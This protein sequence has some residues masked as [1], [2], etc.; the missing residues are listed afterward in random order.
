MRGPSRHS[1]SLV[2]VLGLALGGLFFLGT[3]AC[4]SILGNDG[5]SLAPGDAGLEV[6]DEVTNLDAPFDSSFDQHTT[7]FDAAETAPMMETSAPDSP[8]DVGH[9]SGLSPLLTIPPSGTACDPAEGDG[10]CP[11]GTTCRISSMSEGTCDSFTV[12]H[13]AGYPCSLDSDCGDTL[14]CYKGECFV[15]CPLGVTCAGGCDCFTVGSD[16]TGLCCPGM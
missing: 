16:D 3:P 12:D 13:E 7:G 2:S 15:L 6:G 11:E 9:D 8:A 4:N 5:W 14:Q 10:D 1:R